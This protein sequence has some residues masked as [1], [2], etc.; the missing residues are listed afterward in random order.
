[1]QTTAGGWSVAE[2]EVLYPTDVY[3]KTLSVSCGTLR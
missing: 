2:T 1:M 3:L